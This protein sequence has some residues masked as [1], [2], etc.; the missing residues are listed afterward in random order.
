MDDYCKGIIYCVTNLVNG[1]KYIG[2]TIRTLEL[3][4]KQHLITYEKSSLPFHRALLK[5]GVENFS[6]NIIDTSSS[7][8]ELNEK[9][10]Y[11]IKKLES[12]A[13]TQQGYNVHEGGKG[14]NTFKWMTKDNYDLMIEKLRKINIGND[15]L[16]KWYL[17]ASD[18]EKKEMIEK[19][20]RAN[21]N[22]SK[23]EK[24]KIIKKRVSKWKETWNNKSDNEKLLL[25]QRK[26][27]IM[28]NKSNEEKA[29]SISKM[30][31]T[32]S[33]KSQEEKKAISKKISKALLGKSKYENKTEEEK[34]VIFNNYS[35]AAK[36]KKS[37]SFEKT[38]EELKAISNKNRI[39]RQ[40][41]S[42]EKKQA[43]SILC[44]KNSTGRKNGNWTLNKTKEEMESFSKKRSNATKGLNNPRCVKVKCL[45]TNIIYNS[46]D[47]ASSLVFKD[48]KYRFRIYLSIKEKRSVKDFTWIKVE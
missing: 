42:D 9:E 38:E 34:K 1:K 23:E 39:T 48:V 30:A 19:A 33:K 44:S 6:W 32:M 26:S 24:D 47:E 28:N 27:T 43:F 21:S 4:K 3:R 40:A 15:I 45:E 22:K 46:I 14:G 37:W 10:K 16:Q 31:K 41:W 17:S 5:Y 36:N 18:E 12:Y 35:N 8:N 20:K 29:I 2:Q 25:R 7:K 11:W 13:S